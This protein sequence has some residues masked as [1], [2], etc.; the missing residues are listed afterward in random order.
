MEVNKGE[1]IALLGPNGAG[2][3]TL[4]STICGLLTTKAVKIKLMATIRL[5]NIAKPA[6]N[7]ISAPGNHVRTIR[8][9]L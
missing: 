7:W 8:N 2:K 3:T 1:I 5:L 4:I 9:S 6:V